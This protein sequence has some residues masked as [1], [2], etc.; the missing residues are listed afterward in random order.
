MGSKM[1]SKG[2]GPDVPQYYMRRVLFKA[3]G[4]TDEDLEKPLVAIA[5]T[6]NEI[7]P[8]SYH[9]D[10]IAAAVK[11]GIHQAGGMATIFN[12]L[13]PCDGQ[14]S[15]NVGFKYLLPSRDLIA[16][17]VEMMIEH[18][19]YDAAVMIGTCD[20]II[21]GLIMAAARCNLPTILV[22]GGYMPA[23]HYKGDRLDVASMGKYFVMYKQAKIT[24][25]ELREVED[26]VCPGPGACCLMGTANSMAV[27]AES[28]GLSLPGNSALCATD[29]ALE[30]LAEEAG[31]R[32]ME[33]LWKDLRA[34]DIMTPAAFKNSVKV[35]CATSGSTN[36]T[37]H[38]P[39]IAHELDYPFTLDDFESISQQTPSIMEIKPSDPRYL[40]EDFARAG[41]LQAVMK[42]MESLL[43]TN[44]MT[45]SGRSL[46]DNL[47][48][49]EI[50]DPEI[51]RPLS[52][53]KGKNGGIAILKG[54]MGVAVVKQTA[55]RPE[56]QR[57]RGPARVFEQEED[58]IDALLAGQVK[59]G[60]VLVIRYEG[61]K[62]GPGMREMV[63]AT[64]LLVDMGLDRSTAIVTDGRFSGTSGGP[65]IG[66]LV[67][68]AMVGGPI[69]VLRDGDIIDIDIPS[70]MVNVELSDEEIRRRLLLWE[71]PQ[72]KVTKGY[73]A[74]FAKYA[75]SADKG[76]YLE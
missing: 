15:G 70:R 3:M 32:V 24:Q 2:W 54:N 46:A 27:A 4:A 42:S 62:G 5:N 76:A 56:M 48:S 57:H 26:C 29:A 43:D 7:L 22:T 33:L 6:W 13:A 66:H 25:Q 14:G 9:L 45:V 52:N 60:E 64:W 34:R 20:K 61:P 72:P 37:L 59:E 8:G 47:R 12:V 53:P 40:M 31:R 51:I 74:H 17:S 41:G 58:C 21:P 49:A 69:A 50:R 30:R 36:L 28:F 10:R 38:F 23:G 65:C 68:E 67:P 19:S 18:A 73:L 35:C 11:R 63:T 39:A 44:V 71:P 55:V 16:A 1:R 75:T